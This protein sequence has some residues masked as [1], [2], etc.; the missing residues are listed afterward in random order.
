LLAEAILTA[1]PIYRDDGDLR[2]AVCEAQTAAEVALA[3]DER[4]KNY[5]LR[6]EFC[7]TRLTLSN[8][9]ADW[10]GRFRAL[11][12]TLADSPAQSTQ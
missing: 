10:A 5:P 2:R 6:R 8:A 9:P 4:R 12:F 3:F 1:Y 7:A 11:G